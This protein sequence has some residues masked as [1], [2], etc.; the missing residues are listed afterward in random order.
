M[1]ITHHERVGKTMDLLRQE[2][3]PVIEHEF[4]SL[5]RGQAQAEA[6]RS[7]EG[8]RLLM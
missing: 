4:K 2:L 3:G 5:H 1:A 7:T 8:D 6:S